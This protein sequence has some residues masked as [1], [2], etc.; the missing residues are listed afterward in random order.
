MAW[1][2]S[3]A[4]VGTAVLASKTKVGKMDYK[5]PQDGPSLHSV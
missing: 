1:T 2:S 5:D 4:E 3:A